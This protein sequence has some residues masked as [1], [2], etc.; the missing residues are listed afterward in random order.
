M[1]PTPP[2]QRGTEVIKTGEENMRLPVRV[3]IREDRDLTQD[4]ETMEASFDPPQT[5][6]SAHRRNQK[7]TKRGGGD[8]YKTA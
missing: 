7:R 4:P 6:A 3:R 5:K 1:T 8:I 2:N